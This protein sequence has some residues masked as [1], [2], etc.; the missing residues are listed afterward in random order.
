MDNIQNQSNCAE[1][2][3]SYNKAK[4]GRAKQRKAFARLQN[5]T[6]DALRKDH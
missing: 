1:K 6:L 3:K 4:K 2:M 5:E